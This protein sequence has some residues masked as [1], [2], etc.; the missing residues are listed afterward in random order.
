MPP[1]IKKTTYQ[2]SPTRFET[3]TGNIAD[4]VGLG[5]SLDHVD[6]V[7]RENIAAHEHELLNYGTAKLLTVPGLRWALAPAATNST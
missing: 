1:W 6:E 5:A 3:G 7:G 4:A 2:A